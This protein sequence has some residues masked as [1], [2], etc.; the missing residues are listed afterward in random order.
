MTFWR[1]LASSLRLSQRLSRSDAFDLLKAAIARKAGMLPAAQ[2]AG[3]VLAL[4]ADRLP[5]L[6]LEPVVEEF[7]AAHG[8]WTAGQGFQAIWLVGPDPRLTWRLDDCASQ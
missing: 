2:R 8:T 7:R 1:N 5:A 6:A 4:D 3:L